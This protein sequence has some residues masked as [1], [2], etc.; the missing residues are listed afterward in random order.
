MDELTHFRDIIEQALTEHAKGPYSHGE[1]QSEVVFDR[2]RDRYLLL[3]Q[4]W[5]GKKRIH[6][7]LVH[8][9]L[10]DGNVWIQRDG[11][12]EGIAPD[13]V[14]AG[15]PKDRIVFGYRRPETRPLITIEGV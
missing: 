10:I 9:E 8:V 13:L 12:E 15:I 7:V 5:D 4:G 11:L 3:T 2:V 1:L 6:H 14:R